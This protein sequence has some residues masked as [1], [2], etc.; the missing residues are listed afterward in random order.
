MFTRVCIFVLWN[1]QQTFRTKLVNEWVGS[2]TDVHLSLLPIVVIRYISIITHTTQTIGSF[3]N[4]AMYI[5][6]KSLDTISEQMSS[7]KNTPKLYANLSIC[8]QIIKSTKINVLTKYSD[9]TVVPLDQLKDNSAYT[10][11]CKSSL[12]CC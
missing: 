10:S 7:F 4:K 3:V 8:E 2:L 11:F 9:I 6:F 1:Y 12:P 5:L